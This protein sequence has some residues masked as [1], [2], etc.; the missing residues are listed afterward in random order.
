VPSQVPPQAVASEAQ[1]ARAPCGA[2]ATGLQVPTAPATSQASHCP[3]QAASQQTPSTQK[4][5]AHWDAAPQA[6][7]PGSLGVQT[8]AEHQCP[9][10]HWSSAVQA[11]AQAA[12]PQA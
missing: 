12:G 8:P 7:P 6:V 1:G 9:A 3:P 10:A 2:P 11:P 4:P 5:L